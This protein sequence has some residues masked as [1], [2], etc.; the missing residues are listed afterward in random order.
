MWVFQIFQSN[1]FILRKT[2]LRL[3]K[4]IFLTQMEQWDSN[5]R[6]WGLMIAA[7]FYLFMVSSCSK[8]QATFNV[9]SL[10]LMFSCLTSHLSSVL[11]FLLQA[12]VLKCPLQICFLSTASYFILKGKILKTS[13]LYWHKHAIG[14][15]A[16][17]H[18]S[19]H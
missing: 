17:S 18:L 10:F 19:S 7:F 11:S 12:S 15:K 5:S 4:V 8:L 3:R 2:K 14:K 16:K 6:I 9:G 1:S 13:D